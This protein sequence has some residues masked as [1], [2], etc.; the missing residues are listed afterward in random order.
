MWRRWPSGINANPIRH[1][2]VF[3][4]S[5]RAGRDNE[6]RREEK[7]PGRES[8]MKTP[9][10]RNGRKKGRRRFLKTVSVGAGATAWLGRAGGNLAAAVEQA[11]VQSSTSPGQIEYPRIFRGRQLRMIAFPL[12][13][14]GTGSISLGGRGQ[15]RDWEIFNRADKG[16]AP[17]YAYASIWAQLPGKKPVAKIAESMIGAP[18]EGV[19]GL[20]SDNSPG[21]QRLDS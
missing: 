20:G 17:P 1:F 3:R 16:N 7:L 5:K 21:L 15:L 14:I 4:P 8:S 12:G 9:E 19:T 2:R 10:K 6:P 13:G 18:Y 11:T